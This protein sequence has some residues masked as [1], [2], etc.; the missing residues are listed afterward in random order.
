MGT[1]EFDGGGGGDADD[2]APSRDDRDLGGDTARRD[3][4]APRDGA[5]PTDAMAARRN[6]MVQRQLVDRGL[7][8]QRVL[9]AM[10][11]VPRE[12]FVPRNL[13]RRSYDDGPLP[14][15]EGQTI[16]QP[17]IVAAMTESAQVAP[18]DRALEIGTGSGYGA[19]VLS[20]VAA[21]VVSV[22]R[23]GLLAKSAADLL[24]SLGY[25]NVTV[26][27]DDGSLGYADGA[28]YDV[29]IVTAA[30]P[31]VPDALLE[32]LA[33]GGRLVMPVER[34]PGDQRLVQV[35]R[36]GDEL[37]EADLGAVRFV[38]LIGDQGWPDQGGQR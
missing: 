33:D 27:T 6:A 9:K 23:H 10:G 31:S 24:A 28:P 17:F 16:S 20:R 18:S 35:T 1:S 12:R 37:V 30:G 2:A 34:E 38:P 14:I 36:H 5:E 22:E 8:D 15:A 11:E 26:V 25:D 13:R 4:A 21:G 19:A 32:Q 3:G 29:I 7:V